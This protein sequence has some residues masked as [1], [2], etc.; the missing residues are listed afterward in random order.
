M[1]TTP[2]ALSKAMHTLAIRVDAMEAQQAATAKAAKI[3]ADMVQE[4]HDALMK[5]TPG[6]DAS[7]LDRA[8]ELLLNVE[9]GSRLFNWVLGAGK[10]VIAIGAIVAAWVALV[11]FGIAGDGKP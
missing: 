2:L 3:T 5:R 10:I 6:H 4:I 8:T 7:F 9:S 11:K 1:A